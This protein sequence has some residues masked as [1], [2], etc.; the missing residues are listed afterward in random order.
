MTLA[1]SDIP[2]GELCQLILLVASECLKEVWHDL[3][4]SPVAP[5]GDGGAA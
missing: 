3:V 2:Q 5:K 4:V 1:K